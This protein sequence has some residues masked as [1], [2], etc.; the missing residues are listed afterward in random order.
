MPKDFFTTSYLLSASAPTNMKLFYL[1]AGVFLLFI[2]VGSLLPL[3]KSLHKG[4]KSRL[5]NYFLTFGI[6]GLIL[7]FFQWQSIPYIGIRA[8]LVT[9]LLLML[10]WYFVI[11]FYIL[12][13]MQ[14]E[15]RLAKNNERY[16]KYL[17]KKKSRK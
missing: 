5:F 10:V 2:L 14:K 12:T 17:P 6:V 16:I 8:I 13:K 3:Y 15:V 7:L 9:F 1:I 4:L 11:V